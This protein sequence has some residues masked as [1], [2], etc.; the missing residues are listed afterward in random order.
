M[1]KKTKWS[2]CIG[3][4]GRDAAYALVS[5]FLMLYVQYT[6]NLTTAQFAVISAGMIACMVWDAINDLLMG[7]I[8]ENTNMKMGKFKPWI[9]IG[10]IANAVCIIA[11][12]TIRPTGWSFVIF[13]IITYLLW[14]MT[15]TM[16]DIA[17]WGV[18][19]TLSSDADTRNSLVT[20]MGIFVCVG[21]F[22]VGGLVPM[23]VAGNAVF[24]YRVIALI[25]GVALVLFQGLTALGI[26]ENERVEN[27]KNLSLKDMF[28][29]FIRN[30][31]LVTMGVAHLLFNIGSNL[32]IVFGVNFFYIEFG[33]SDSGDLVTIFTVMYGLG[34]LVAQFIYG[35]LNKKFSRMQILTVVIITIT[36][37]YVAFLGLGYVL[38]KNIILLNILGFIIFLGQGIFNLNNV[39]MINNTI[40]YDEVRYH[41]RH[42]SVISAVRSFSVK[43]AGGLNQ[44]ISTLTLIVS[45]IYVISQN[46]SAL[47]I[48]INKGSMTKEAALTQANN[49]IAGITT[50][51]GLIF[52]ICM[53]GV[54]IVTLLASYVIIK[55]KYKID[56]KEYDRLVEALR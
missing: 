48:E 29:I 30:D 6:M 43:L 39:V 32:L 40:E 12:F 19:P 25:V 11:L 21:Q 51:Q 37:A 18:L 16:N 47:E 5:M 34:T 2:Y 55:L 13:Y 23:V 44:G 24:A 49:Y 56:E 4:T 8:I 7:I 46:I 45:G 31:Q 17:Y 1:T 10:S 42:D 41:E 22:L 35:P 15:Y 38:P 54:P 20:T 9:L 26:T 3:A 14:G 36:V 28:K 53:V 33:Y 52:R 50:T 27:T